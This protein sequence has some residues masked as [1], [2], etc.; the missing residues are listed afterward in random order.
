MEDP[1]ERQVEDQAKNR[2]KRS[3]FLH[4]RKKLKFQQVNIFSSTLLFIPSDSPFDLKTTQQ[5]PIYPLEIPGN[6]SSTAL[7]IL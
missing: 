7:L 3:S 1:L 4:E 5:F 2:L 6:T